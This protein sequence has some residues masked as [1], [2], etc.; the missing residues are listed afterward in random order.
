MSSQ[1]VKTALAA[2]MMAVACTAPAL[3][4]E[5]EVVIGNLDDLS[6]VYSDDGGPGSVE[7]MRMA[8]ADFGGSVLGRKV[9]A[10]VA[11]HQNKP[12]IGASRF[13]E[14]ADQKGVGMMIAGANTGVAIAM[15]KVAVAKK[16]PLLIVGAGG[17]SLTN[18]DCTAYSIHYVFDTTSLANGTASTVLKAGGKTWFYLAADYAFGQQLQGS[19]SRVVEAGGG[20]NLGSVRV[21]LSTADFSSYLLQAQS[22]G[23]QVLAFANAGDDFQNALKAAREFGITKTMRPVALVAFINN[24]HSLGLEAAQGLYLTTSWY[25]D[26]NDETRAFARRFFAKM[27]AQPTMTQA[28]TY[29]ATLT[30]LKA[31]KAAGATDSD[32]VMAELRRT[33]IDDMFAKGGYIRADG[34]MIHDMYVMQ[35]KSPHESKYPWDYY[36]VITVMPGAE[37]FGPI[38]GRC[39]LAPK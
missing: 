21:P 4:A 34:V 10:L 30:Y 2:V 9:V 13:R 7:A 39:P 6:G 33:K 3:A 1:L 31:V 35:V 15:T 25:W 27:K 37:A 19:A 29:S 22:S 36:K 38:T 23:A 5:G 12:D 16:V 17:A 20:R 11:D 18:E 14:W 32:K 8:I 28:G 24:I 26:L